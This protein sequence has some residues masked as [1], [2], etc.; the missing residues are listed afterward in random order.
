MTGVKSI[1]GVALVMAVFVGASV[2]AALLPLP[3]TGERDVRPFAGTGRA[4]V[5]TLNPS[6]ARFVVYYGNNLPWQAFA[7]YSVVVFDRDKHPPLS[8]L[9]A[10]SRVLLAY[11]SIGEVEKSR[12]DYRAIEDQGL[13]LDTM[14]S[15]NGAAVVDV[16]KREWADYL[17]NSL[18]PAVTAQGFDGIML[19]TADSLIEME[20]TEPVRYA[21]LSDATVDLIKVIRERYPHLVI[22]LNRGF[23][24]LPRVD[25]DIDLVLAESIFTHWTGTGTPTLVPDATYRHYEA[26]LKEVKEDAS[27]LKVATIDYWPTKDKETIRRIYATQR[28]NGFIPYVTEP[29]LQSLTPEPK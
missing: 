2:A 26:L 29:D 1:S 16:R 3:F 28:A 4:M 5:S 21:G 15:W 24:I 7:P 25:R 9:R 27:R 20:R 18:I 10:P 13:V 22:M 23:E 6:T 17:L 11:V 14:S 19:D 8:S 12:S